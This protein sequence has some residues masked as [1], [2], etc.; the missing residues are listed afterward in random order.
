MLIREEFITVAWMNKIRIKP[1]YWVRTSCGKSWYYICIW[2]TIQTSK[3]FFIYGI[4]QGQNERPWCFVLCCSVL[5]TSASLSLSE[6]SIR[7]MRKNLMSGKKRRIKKTTVF[8]SVTESNQR[9]DIW[10]SIGDREFVSNQLN[11][12]EMACEWLYLSNLMLQTKQ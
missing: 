9:A 12:K 3:G 2:M 10:N 1:W 11:A 8:N 6:I 7:Q 5:W 4:V